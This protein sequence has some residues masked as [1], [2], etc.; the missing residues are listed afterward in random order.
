MT[1]QRDLDKLAKSLTA[2]PEVARKISRVLKQDA[3][4]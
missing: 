2:L 1:T 3:V 4:G